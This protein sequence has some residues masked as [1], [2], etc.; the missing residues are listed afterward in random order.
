MCNG[1]CQFC[2]QNDLIKV[3]MSYFC[4]RY[5]CQII[6]TNG[7]QLLC[8]MVVVNLQVLWRLSELIQSCNRVDP[9][10]GP[11][12]KIYKYEWVGSGPVR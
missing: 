6:N 4:E 1:Y 3:W 5:G 2:T 11:G 9:R 7:V 12:Q 10:V 8:I